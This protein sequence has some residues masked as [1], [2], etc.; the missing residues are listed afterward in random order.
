MP[1][2][3]TTLSL[4]NS[5]AIS[6]RRNQ[7]WNPCPIILFRR[8]YLNNFRWLSSVWI[9]TIMPSFVSPTFIHWSCKPYKFFYEIK[10]GIWH[11]TNSVLPNKTKS[12]MCTTLWKQPIDLS[13][14]PAD[15]ILPPQATT[16]QIGPLLVL[17]NVVFL[18][19]WLIY[20]SNIHQMH[21][22]CTWNSY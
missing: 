5:L 8:M 20:I 10:Q 4:M 11:H 13:L 19:V 2:H 21:S 7:G 6:G 18:C 9:Q 16:K 14:C 12:P 22:Q 17:P 1:K 15:V 3:Q